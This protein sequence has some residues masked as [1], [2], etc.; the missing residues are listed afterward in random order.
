MV[1]AKLTYEEGRYEVR[2]NNTVMLITHELSQ[3]YKPLLCE[4][5][6]S[7]KKRE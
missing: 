7:S 1:Q 3:D 2:I 5:M 6:N 4:K